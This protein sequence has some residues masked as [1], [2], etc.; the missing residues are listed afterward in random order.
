MLEKKSFEDNF[1]HSRNAAQITL[2]KV[3]SWEELN[4]ATVEEGNEK[5]SQKTKELWNEFAVSGVLAY[6]KEKGERVLKPFTD[7]D[8][9]SALGILNQ[10]GIDTSNLSFVKPGESIESAINLDTGDKFGVVYNEDTY[11]AYFDHHEK[12]KKEVTSTAEVM[13]KTMVDLGILEQSEEMDRVVDF[14]TKIDNRKFPPE[15]FLRSAKTILGLQR[16]LKFEQLLAYFKDHESPTEE[17]SPEEFEKYGLKEAAEK[18][19]KVVDEAMETLQRMEEEEKIVQTS[20]GSVVINENNELKVGSSAA[21]VKHDGILNLTPGK[22]FAITFKDKDIDEAT[23]K[24]KLGD[25]FQGKIIRGKMWIY[26]DDKSL[27]LTKEELIEA[28]G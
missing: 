7:L 19:Q 6:D 5:F 2:D 9:N 3:S 27:N 24:E 4:A 23:I 12:G 17:L 14:V 15:E 8:G 18:Q 25:K 1:E 16:G 21:Y 20:Y 28:L 10:A 26:N 13:Y 22:S 11:T